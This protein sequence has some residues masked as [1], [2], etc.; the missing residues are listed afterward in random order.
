[1][2]LAMAPLR[3][4]H[5]CT[6]ACS[7]RYAWPNLVNQPCKRTDALRS[8][9]DEDIDALVLLIVTDEIMILPETASRSDQVGEPQKQ[10]L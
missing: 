7:S 9:K 2:V 3:L 6:V 5:C 10:T 8:P 1:M 4:K